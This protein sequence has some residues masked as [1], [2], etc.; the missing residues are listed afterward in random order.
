MAPELIAAEEVQIRVTR[1]TDVWAFGMTVVEVCVYI[2]SRILS[3]ANWHQ[4]MLQIL[5]DRMPFAHIV[6][7]AGV[8]VTVKE[9][10]RPNRADCLKIPDNIW[11]TLERC[12]AVDPNQRP[13]SMTLCQFFTPLSTNP[14]DSNS[15]TI[16]DECFP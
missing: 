16:T 8:I 15:S 4:N 3:M 1:A 10:G 13:S 2:L 12:W 9:G 6:N 14:P 7:A 5:T 11:R